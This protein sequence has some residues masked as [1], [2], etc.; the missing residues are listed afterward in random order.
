MATIFDDTRSL[1]D[2]VHSIGELLTGKAHI[3]DHTSFDDKIEYRIYH[4]HGYCF[5]IS[6]ERQHDGS[7]ELD[8]P[9]FIYEFYTDWEGFK[10]LTEKEALSLLSLIKTKKERDGKE[11]KI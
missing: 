8:G 11:G 4:A 6:K 2:R 3:L 1:F 10:D 5:D 7:D 9:E